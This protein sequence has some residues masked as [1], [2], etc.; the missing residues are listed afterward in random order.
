MSERSSTVTA[1]AAGDDKAVGTQAIRRALAVLQLFRDTKTD[2]GNTQIANALGL[3]P[4][5]THR[6]VRAL[7]DEGYLTQNAE[8]ER[9]YLSREAVLLG[10]AAQRSLGLS[11]ALPVLERVSASTSESV[12][13]GVSDGTHALV[14]LRVESPLPL[15]FD[16][17]PGTRV[18]LHAS[19]MGKA[20]LAFGG[21]V[22]SYVETLGGGLSSY[23]PHTVTSVPALRKEIELTRERG[24]SLDDEES[25][26]GVRCVGAPIANASGRAR[27]AAAI[28]APSVRLPDS[29]IDKLAEEI[30]TA[31]AEIADLLPPDHEF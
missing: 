6:I 22:D 21:D 20:L 30:V 16:Q 8:N 7:V 18:P 23:T 9:Y 1:R 13:L 10:L 31:A 2:L 19:S 4:S 17:P 29:R 3:R 25:I 26:T 27:A 28:Q 15:R 11:A 24:Y 5:T 14:V 12:N